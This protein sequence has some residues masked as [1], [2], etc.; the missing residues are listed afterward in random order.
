LRRQL[1]DGGASG[2]VVELDTATIDEAR[3]KIL[4]ARERVADGVGKLAL[5]TD[6]TERCA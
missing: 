2:V 5:L 3:Q 4:A 1:L 6:Q